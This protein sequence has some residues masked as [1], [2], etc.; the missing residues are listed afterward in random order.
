MS[1]TQY[2]FTKMNHKRYYIMSKFDKLLMNN[3]LRS[4]VIE[5]YALPKLMSLSGNT[6]QLSGKS[7]LELGCG[8]G[9]GLRIIL[10][11][12]RPE[13]FHAMD[14]DPEMVKMSNRKISRIV[15]KYPDTQTNIYVGD[16]A[17]INSC[18]NHYDVVFGFGVLHHIPVWQSSVQE[19]FR[20]LRPG[21]ILLL[22][23]SFA[24]FIMHP[25]WRRVMDHPQEN[26]FDAPEL[27]A[28]LE[29]C[30][31]INIKYQQSGNQ[32]MG[33]LAAYKPG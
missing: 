27:I 16:A 31:F 6:H 33:W 1:N 8:N 32:F 11:K 20:V 18:D 14:S 13:V 7:I 26:R 3:P 19:I 21:G 4:W 9:Y 28:C 29:H 22:E 23:E 2:Q 30:G 12:F 10:K 15:K 24:K 5:H 17:A 25:F